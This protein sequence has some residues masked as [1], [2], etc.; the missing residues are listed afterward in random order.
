[1]TTATPGPRTVVLVNNKTDTPVTF[2]MGLSAPNFL[3]DCGFITKAGIPAGK[4]TTVNV[5]W[6]NPPA[7]GPCYWVRAVMPAPNHSYTSVSEGGFCLVNAPRWII[8]VT[9]HGI[10]LVK[11]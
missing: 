6:S 4:S 8:N 5:P 9:N 2:I 7:T 11:P 3:G 1:M 10:R